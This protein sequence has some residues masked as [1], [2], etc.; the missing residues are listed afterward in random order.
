MS[1]RTYQWKDKVKDL[2]DLIDTNCPVIFEGNWE[3]EHK[4]GWRWVMNLD[5]AAPSGCKEIIKDYQQGHGSLNVCV[6]HAF[7]EKKMKPAPTAVFCGLY[8]RDVEDLIREVE[9]DLE[10]PVKVAAWLAS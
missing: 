8:V 1:I 5:L 2:R 3:S 6:G 9:R 10:D 7:D 4:K